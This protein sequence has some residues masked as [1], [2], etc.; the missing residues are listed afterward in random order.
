MREAHGHSSRET[1]EVIVSPSV[2]D[3]ISKESKGL[4]CYQGVQECLSSLLLFPKL[5]AMC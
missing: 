2:M 3:M 4:V 1:P 5:P